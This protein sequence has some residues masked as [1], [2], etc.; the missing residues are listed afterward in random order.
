MSNFVLPIIIGVVCIVIGIS[1]MRGNIS[2]LHSYHRHRV[3]E[4]DKLP[5]GKKVG[6]GM[7]IVGISIIVCNLFYIAT[8]YT[9]NEIFNIIG[10]VFLIFGLTVGIAISIFAIIK[11]NKGLF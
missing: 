9:K 6:L 3:S 8:F 10:T 1:N 5:M 11:Y 4:E 7:I 2:T